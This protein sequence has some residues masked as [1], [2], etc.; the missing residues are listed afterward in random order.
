MNESLIDVKNQSLHVNPEF[1]H[2]YEAM[3]IGSKEL[4]EAI[5]KK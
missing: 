4:D 5:S 1:T 2:V 3:K